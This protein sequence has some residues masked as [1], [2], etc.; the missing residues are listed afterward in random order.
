MAIPPAPV[1]LRENVN[2]SVVTV[3]SR[4][5][6][7]GGQV[8]KTMDDLYEDVVSWP[9]HSKHSEHVQKVANNQLVELVCFMH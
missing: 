6:C 7:Q 1:A 2:T 9:K 5:G 3:R 4:L 8:C